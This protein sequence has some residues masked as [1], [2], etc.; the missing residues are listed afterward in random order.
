V[1]EHETFRIVPLVPKESRNTLKS[2]SLYPV[3]KVALRSLE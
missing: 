1:L 3:N 2:L